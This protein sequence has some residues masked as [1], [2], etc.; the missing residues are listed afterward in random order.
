V[1]G[2][3]IEM[4]ITKNH[5]S[6]L[7]VRIRDSEI[8]VSILVLFFFGLL[9][10]CLDW[11]F[12]INFSDIQVEAHGLIMDVFVFGI[13]ILWINKIRDR[14]NLRL[15]YHE[16]IDDFRDWKS[17]EAKYRILGTIKRLARL[18]EKIFDVNR[19]Y[20]WG[21]HLENISFEDSNFN[22]TNL[23]EAYISNCSFKRV[24]FTGA[25]LAKANIVRCLFYDCKLDRANFFDV[26]LHEIDFLGSDLTHFDQ[27]NNLDKARKIYNPKN[28]D[29]NLFALIKD[30]RPDLLEKPIGGYVRF[31]TDDK[32]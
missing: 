2:A 19:A 8:K 28:L 6:N 27:S 30:K 3:F 21:I 1:F 15:R 11:K 16:K 25:S 31:L 22:C 18:G 14:H 23:T 5:V 13:L 24:D 32:D 20:L 9:I 26:I 10:L 17:D 12:G 4:K 7:I 29:D